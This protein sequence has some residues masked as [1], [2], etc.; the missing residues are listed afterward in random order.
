MKYRI[1]LEVAFEISEK[2][3]INEDGFCSVFADKAEEIIRN[4]LP[5]DDQPIFDDEQDCWMEEEGGEE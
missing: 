4:L 3:I 1:R 2:T 5:D